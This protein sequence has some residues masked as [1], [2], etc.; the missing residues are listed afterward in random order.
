M[1]GIVSVRYYQNLQ[2]H[3]QS[4]STEGQPLVDQPQTVSTTIDTG[5]SSGRGPQLL[6]PRRIAL[7]V[8]LTRVIGQGRF[9][10]VNLG[11]WNG[12]EVACKIFDSKDEDRFIIEFKT[13]I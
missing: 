10:R 13:L 4:E 12:Q 11:I 5:M 6:V 9:G 8:E 7:E 1:S 3:F 2:K